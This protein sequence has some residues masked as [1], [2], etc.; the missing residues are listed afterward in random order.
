MNNEKSNRVWKGVSMVM[1]GC[2][3][4]NVALE[5]LIREDPGCGSLITVFQFLFIAVEGIFANLE[6]TLPANQPFSLLNLKYLRLRQ[7]IVPIS[8]YIIMVI[9][10]W[11]VSVINNAALGYQIALPLHMVFRSGS[12]ITTMLFGRFVFRKYYTNKQIMA[13]VTVTLGIFLATLSSAS[14]KE[15]KKPDQDVIVN[16]NEQGFATWTIGILMLTFGLVMSSVLGL[17][18]TH[19][20]EKHK[21]LYLDKF[22]NKIAEV[23]NLESGEA[24]LNQGPSEAEIK[25]RSKAINSV[26]RES[27][28]Y[29]HLIA[30]PIFVVLLPDIVEHAQLWSSDSIS[31]INFDLKFFPR[32]AN[33]YGESGTGDFAGFEISVMWVYLFFNVISQ[34]FVYKRCVCVVGYWVCFNYNVGY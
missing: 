12:L 3:L 29:S 14:V 5:F 27:M 10:F 1:V 17:Y 6:W 2:M 21:K 9:I 11:L 32:N 25:E 15:E 19:T 13:V 33:L 20:F 22:K 34:F 7:R 23:M 16:D 4:N 31:S 26:D 30:L 8:S 24:K 28:F 18:Q